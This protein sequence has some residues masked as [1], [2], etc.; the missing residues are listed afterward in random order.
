MVVC[1]RQQKIRASGLPSA[2]FLVAN[3]RKKRLLNAEDDDRVAIFHMPPVDDTMRDMKQIVRLVHQRYGIGRRKIMR[4][5][6]GGHLS[7][8]SSLF[9]P[10]SQVLLV[11]EASSLS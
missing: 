10:S 5:I 8:I 7:D 11:E 2:P 3:I 6:G 9:Q 4:G 1:I